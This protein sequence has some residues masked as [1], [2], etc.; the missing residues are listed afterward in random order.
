L[1]IRWASII[2]LSSLRLRKYNSRHSVYTMATPQSDQSRKSMPYAISSVDIRKWM[3]KAYPTLK[4]FLEGIV[5]ERGKS[6]E[7]LD[8]VFESFQR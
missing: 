3:G 5:I 6:E 8:A 4:I 1:H 2:I 7:Y